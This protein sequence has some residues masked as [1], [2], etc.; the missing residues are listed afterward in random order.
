LFFD[1]FYFFE[2]M[3]DEQLKLITSFAKKKSFEK[4]SI[5]FYEKDEAKSLISVIE[6]VLK[7]YKTDKKAIIFANSVKKQSDIY[8][9]QLRECKKSLDRNKYIIF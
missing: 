1:Q 6:G 5:L 4:G 8:K 3:T 9:S 2:N 7:V